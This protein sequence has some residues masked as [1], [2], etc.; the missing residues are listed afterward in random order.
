MVL[1]SIEQDIPVNELLHL[2]DLGGDDLE[3]IEAHI[4]GDSP[5]I[6][7]AMRDLAMPEG[8][9]MFAVIRDGEATPLGPDMVLRKATRS[10][11][12]ASASARRSCTRS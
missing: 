7:R 1:A 12:S 9:S 11:R 5:A 8:C 10:S 2:A 4:A 6:G 3:L